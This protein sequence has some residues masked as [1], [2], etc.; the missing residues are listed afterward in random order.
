MQRRGQPW[1]RQLSCRRRMRDPAAASASGAFTAAQAP[2]SHRVM[3]CDMHT[4]RIPATHLW[5]NQP[6]RDRHVLDG[7]ESRSTRQCAQC[8]QPS[9]AAEGTDPNLCQSCSMMRYDSQQ[10]AWGRCVP[11]GHS[12]RCGDSLH[13][14]A[15]RALPAPPAASAS[16]RRSVAAAGTRRS[17]LSP[18][19]QPLW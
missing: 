6:M 17:A 10:D 5:Q 14:G 19:P 11:L 9:G 7:T 8:T 16:R 15:A 2:C 12:L 18:V 13:A 1:R 4:V 3:A